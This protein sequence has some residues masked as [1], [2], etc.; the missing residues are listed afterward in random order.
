MTFR[1]QE[2]CPLVFIRKNAA[3]VKSWEDLNAPLTLRSQRPVQ[4]CVCGSLVTESRNRTRWG[5]RS[6]PG[7]RTPSRHS[8][9]R[10]SSGCRCSVEKQRMTKQSKDKSSRFGFS[11]RSVVHLI[12]SWQTQTRCHIASQADVDRH[13]VFFPLHPFFTLNR[14]ER[15]VSA[16]CQLRW[17]V[18]QTSFLW[19]DS[20]PGAA[21]TA[22]CRRGYGAAIRGCNQRPPR[23]A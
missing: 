17:I 15:H 11:I 7:R 21:Q 20:C 3:S 5:R 10:R 9:W 13:I 8:S 6:A 23:R 22:A 4:S 12:I 2:R 1:Q 19:A 16:A 14:L 18:N